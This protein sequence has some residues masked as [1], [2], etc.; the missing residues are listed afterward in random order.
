MAGVVLLA[1][2]SGPGR[3]RAA[4]ALGVGG[5]AA[6]ARRSGADRR[7]RV[8]PVG[9]GDGRAAGVG[10]PARG[11]ARRAG[12]R[13]D[14]T[15]ARGEPRDL[16]RG[17]GRDAAR[18]RSRRSGGCR[19]CR[20]S[21]TSRSCPWSRSRCWA[22]CVAMLAGGGDRCSARRAAVATLAGLPGW[23]VLHVVVAIVRI[24]GG[25][26]VRRGHA[27][28]GR[29]RGRRGS[30]PA[31]RSSPA[32]PPSARLRRPPAA[33]TARGGRRPADRGRERTGAASSDAS[34]RVAGRRRGSSSPSRGAAFGDATDR[35]DADHRPRRRAGRR[36][37]AR[38]ADRRPDAG[39][40]RPRSRTGSWSRSTSGSRRGTG[41]STSSCSPIRTRTT[42]RGS[43]GSSSAT[44]SGASTSPA[45]AGPGPGWAAWDAVLHDG[46]PRGVLATGARLRLGEVAA[47]GPVA[48]PGRRA[49]RAAG[50]RDRRST[51]SRS[52][53]WARRTA[54]GSC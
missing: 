20:R 31:S 15:L 35:D 40:R 24:G 34:Q 11:V 39:R 13:T 1:R 2:E 8:P 32:R 14:A 46:P 18:R 5:R 6:A 27:A 4:A 48:G 3:A 44:P 7:R 50:H 33:A 42:S 29:R 26:P 47:R 49:A 25:S 12:R 53:S 37:P 21:S 30:R 36:D 19:S 45:C 41:G 23:L 22:A 10:E 52:C 17:A 51:T 16:A 9:A 38:D 54:G 28:A 43:P